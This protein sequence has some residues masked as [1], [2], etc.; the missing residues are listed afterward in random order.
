[1]PVVVEGYKELI[2][3]LNAFEPDLN[4][5]MKIEIKAAML[6]IRDKARGYAPSPYPSYLYNWADKGIVR[7]QP[8]FNTEG[9][10]RKFPL[11]NTAEVIA[12][13]KYKAGANKKTRYGFSALYSVINTSAAGAIYEWAGRTSG[14]RGQPWVGPKGQGKDV[15]RSRNPN[16]GAIFINSMGPMYGQN[17]FKGR[18]IFRAWNESQGKAQDAVV[19]AIEKAAR[20]FNERATQSAFGLVA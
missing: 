18:L 14:Y 2:Q 17:K 12:G 10:V 20:R 5:Q 11:Y 6:P 4:K 8:Q 16:A 19:H 3:K 13:I 7:A 1:M 9:R 15:S